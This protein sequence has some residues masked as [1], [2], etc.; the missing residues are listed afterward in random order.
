M[1]DSAAAENA[2]NGLNNTSIDGRSVKVM[3][4]RPKEERR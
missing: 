1:P 2:V 3:E 4:A